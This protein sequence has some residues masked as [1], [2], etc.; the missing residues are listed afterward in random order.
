[1]TVAIPDNLKDLVERPIVCALATLMP[2][3]QPQVTPVWFE[4]DDHHIVINTARGR[5]KDQNMKPGAKV[6]LLIIDPQNPYHWAELRGQIE[7]ETE[8][9][10][11]D[12]I[13]RLA[14]KYR[15]KAEYPLREG[16]VRVTYKIAIQKVN[17]S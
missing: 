4:Y 17:G 6:T 12:V 3:G 14:L 2:S 7:V 8:A 5:Q 9:G 16:E 11:H 13:K 15:G 1:M 10:A